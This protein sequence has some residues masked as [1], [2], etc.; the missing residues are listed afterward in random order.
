MNHHAV[1][2]DGLYVLY[3]MTSARRLG[4]NF[5]LDHAV[6][7]CRALGKPLVIFEGLRCDYPWASD[8]LHRFVLQGMEA[9]AALV[10]E[11]GGIVASGPIVAKADSSSLPLLY[12]PWIE[13]S[14]HQGRGLLEA[15][16][17]QACVVVADDFPCFF[18]PRM[19]EAAAKKVSTRIEAV[20]S[21]GLL[22]IRASD[23]PFA[24]AFDFRRFVQKTL[25]QHFDNNPT[26]NPLA[27]LPTDLNASAAFTSFASTILARWPAL[28]LSRGADNVTL[29]ALPIDHSIKGAWAR[30]GTIH[31]RSRLAEFM[32]RS[33]DHYG[34]GRNHPDDDAASGLSAWLHF[35]HISAHEIFDA[36]KRRERWTLGKLAPKVTASREGWWGMSEAGEGFL[37][38]LITWRELGY[39]MCATRPDYDR[40]E[41]LP[42]WAQFTIDKHADDPRPHQYSQDQFARAATHDPLWNAAQRQLIREGRMHNYLRMLWGKK[43]VEWSPD[44]RTAL[45]T[46]IELNNR[47]A[48]DGRNPNSYSGILWCLG[49]YDR[50]WG[51]ERPIMGTL[52][53]MT[54][55]STMKKLRLKKYLVKYGAQTGL[56]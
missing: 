23:K 9:N 48:L 33:F 41:S 13:S 27:S 12:L 8:R 26:A 42:A 46:M 36:V 6:A 49:R 47:F 30:G 56:F 21:N 19:V 5:A 1:R 28:V 7:W 34:E 45:A 10:G 52:R 51:P 14:K 37:D 43:I 17:S 11:L 53:Y 4:W 44:A 16:S 3:W 18:L 32:A 40:F 15:L 24:R 31:A 39:N 50:A 38:E 55:D 35:G 29:D 54:S 22:P 20:D 2:R 25:P